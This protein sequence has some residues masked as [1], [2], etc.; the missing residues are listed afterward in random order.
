MEL[1]LKK[2]IEGLQY[3]PIKKLNK[4]SSAKQRLF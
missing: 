3:R 4:V 2:S 1:Q